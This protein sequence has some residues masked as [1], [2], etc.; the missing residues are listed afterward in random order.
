MAAPESFNA[1]DFSGSYVMSYDLSTPNDDVLAAQVGG[2][3][4]Y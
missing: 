4:L 3:A 1:S 2:W